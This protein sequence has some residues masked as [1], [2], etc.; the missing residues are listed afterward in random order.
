MLAHMGKPFLGA[1]LIATVTRALEEGLALDAAAPDPARAQNGEG[2]APAY[3][4]QLRRSFVRS[5]H[6]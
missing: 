1:D 5:C 4:Q 3:R 6:L 2:R